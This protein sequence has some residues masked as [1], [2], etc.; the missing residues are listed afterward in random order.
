MT[1]WYLEPLGKV[2]MLAGDDHLQPL[3]GLGLE[4]AHLHL[5]DDAVDAGAVVLERQVDVA[6]AVARHLGHLA[7]KADEA[8][9]VL[10]RPLEREGE[11]ETEYGSAFV[12][13]GG[14]SRSVTG[15]I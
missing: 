2:V 1:I 7:P 9:G 11:L 12:A 4:L 6:A 10:H 14:E 5:P 13:G 15:G 8:V 3:G